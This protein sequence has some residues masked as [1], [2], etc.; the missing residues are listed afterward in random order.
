MRIQLITLFIIVLL[1]QL[2]ATSSYGQR[3]TINAT[4]T[5]LEAVLK[6]IKKQSGFDLIYNPEL[7]TKNAEL[8]TVRSNNGHLEYVL[9][10]IFK[11]QSKLGFLVNGTTIIIRPKS[12]IKGDLPEEPPALQQPVGGRVTNEKG[13]PLVGASIYVLDTQG[14]RTGLHTKTNERGDFELKDVAEGQLIEISYLGHSSV[15]RNAKTQLGTIVLKTISAE[16]E[17]IIVNAG[18]YTVKDKE[19]TGSIA[20]VTA[21]EIENQPV[22]NILSALQGRV[23]GLEISE[24]S[25]MIGSAVKVRL[26]GTNSIAAGNDPFYVIDGVPFDATSLSSSNVATHI[27]MGEGGLSP[28][29][30]LSTADIESIEVLKDAD[31]TAI[32][33]SRGSNGVILIT[34]KRGNSGKTRLNAS[35]DLGITTPARFMDLLNTEEY[36]KLRKAAYAEDGVTEYPSYAYDVNGDWDPNRYTNWQKALVGRQAQRMASQLG[37]SGGS[38]Q[39]NFLINGTYFKQV[40]S[41]SGDFSYQK[42]GV[43]SSIHHRSTDQRLQVK[44]AVSYGAEFNNLP[45]SDITFL[46][47]FRAPNA[48]KLYTEEGELNWAPGFNNPL[49]ELKK[50]YE[51]NVSS[52]NTSLNLSYQLAKSLSFSTNLGYNNNFLEEFGITPNTIYNPAFNVGPEASSVMIHAGRRNNWIIEPQLTFKRKVFVGELDALVGASL[53]HSKSKTKTERGSGF[54]SNSLIYD[55]RSATYFN[56]IATDDILYKYHAL[57]GRINYNIDGKYIIN[58]TARRDGSSRFGPGRQF[59]NFGALGA[60]WVFSKESWMERHSWLN[61]GKIRASYGITGNDQI[62]DYQYLNTFIAGEKYGGIIGMTPRQHFN[63]DFSWENNTKLEIGADLTFLNDRF[64]LGASFYRNRSGN[65]LVGMPLSA[66]TGFEKIQANMDALVE[67]KGFE[68]TVHTSNVTNNHFSWETDLMLS[69]PKNKLIS[70]PGLTYS[71]YAS[72]LVV[73]QP[74]TIK[75]VY[76][77]TGIDPDTGIYTF[78]DVNG[79]GELTFGDD[80]QWVTFMGTHYHASLNNTF[81]YGPFQ[82]GVFFQYVNQTGENYIYS[83]G[84]TPGYAAENVGRETLDNW[85]YNKVNPRFQRLTSGLNMEAIQAAAKLRNSD[86]HVSDASFLRLKNVNLTY[87]LPRKWLGINGRIYAQG[88]NLM[89]FTSYL[90][91]DPESARADVLPLLRVWNF[92][93]QLDF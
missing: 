92:G 76:H 45:K 74:L 28:F 85:T 19:R 68:L 72:T 90:G 41:F 66:V 12:E 25:G 24:T 2:S 22:T 33:G 80:R 52:L 17:E 62:G 27:A 48:P 83:K 81:R 53:Q 50:K 89:T 61:F 78:E 86:A 44:M 42:A 58:A 46:E 10:D 69:V 30:I 71:P 6:E 49:A 32:Y 34:T 14:K 21:K 20:R 60:A 65:Q 82:L 93:F 4:G 63:S 40:P 36:I 5:S 70:F 16:V 38:D 75:K 13:E 26:R 23:A 29:N 18:Y 64:S 59:A 84:A 3:V 54:A 43:H 37:I 88:Q 77:Y 31:A 55:I 15:Q 8:V 79:D 7:I 39:T 51:N 91:S 56:L 73:G 57:F 11:K 9:S 67:N 47:T 87:N 1:G 35:M